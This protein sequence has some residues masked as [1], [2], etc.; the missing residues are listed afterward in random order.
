MRRA[1]HCC[2]LVCFLMVLVFLSGCDKP[3]NLV[4]GQNSKI[5]LYP[6]AG[7]HLVWLNGIQ[8]QFL[9]P[10]RARRLVSILPSVTSRATWARASPHSFSI[11]ARITVAAIRKW[12]WE[13]GAAVRCTILRRKLRTL[14]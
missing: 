5:A 1:S 9:G 7:Q 2:V 6:T 4:L 11:S 14:N 10:P 12:M 3:I 8:V 13:A